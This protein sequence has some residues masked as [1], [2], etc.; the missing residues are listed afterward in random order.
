MTKIKIID[1][2]NEAQ[3]IEVKWFTSKKVRGLMNNVK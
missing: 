1:E 3:E 2:S